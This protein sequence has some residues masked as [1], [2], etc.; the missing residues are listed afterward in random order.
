MTA[1]RLP[2]IDRLLRHPASRPL[3]ERH[4]RE[5]VLGGYRSLL[6]DLRDA[7]R[8]G[9][10]TAV[11][12]EEG[13]LAGRLGE[14]LAL[15]S[16]PRVRR[17]FN[18]TGT[19]LHTNLGRALLAEEA[20]AAVTEAARQPMNLEFDL[21]TGKRGD[22]DDLVADLV[23]ELT[24]AEAVTVVN[25][26]AAA[27]LLALHAIGARKEGVLSR[28]E[29]IEIGG[30]FRIPDI[31]ARA[32]VKLVEVGTT[33]RTHARD[34]EAAIGPRTALLMRVHTSNYSV[35]GFTA[36]V[37]TA[38]LAAIARAH[39]VPLLED[40]GSGTLVDLTRWGLPAEPTVQQALRDGADLVTFSGDKL[41]GGPQCGLIV[42]RRD[43]IERIKKNP[44]KR[45]LRVD[46]LT[47]A[48]LEATLALYRDP[49]RLAERLPSLRLLSRPAEAITTQAERLLPAFAAVLGATYAVS[50]EPALGMIG[51]GAQPVARLPGAAL[52]CRPQVS[53]RLRGRA[54]RQLEEGLR[55]LPIPVVGRIDAD[56]LWLDL[57][58]L[59]DEAAFLA[60][61]PALLLPEIR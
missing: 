53:K 12:V 28:G 9:T 22:R 55:Q 47:L 24:G 41:L 59:D 32:G 42:G 19:V 11:E 33:N 36:S 7:L 60:Q 13:V 3:E 51:S 57:R 44:L 56:A 18:L 23:R 2:S 6:D 52:C 14:R 17:V 35:Q 37:A 15:H 54:L 45:A 40:L 27:V 39:D 46:K 8:A 61:L 21:A 29:L 58:Q 38:E 50:V 34:Y 43:L 31:M 26:N 5:L 1:I 25:N 30:A 49:D 10:L 4:G 20:I 48:A 16:Q